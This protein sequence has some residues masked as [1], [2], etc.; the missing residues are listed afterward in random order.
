ME[1]EMRE[2]FGELS[3]AVNKKPK[4]F[5]NWEKAGIVAEFLS[6]VIIAGL[7]CWVT[8]KIG[9]ITLDNSKDI[10]NAQ[11]AV[12]RDQNEIA[13]QAQFAEYLPEASASR[14]NRRRATPL[15]SSLA[16]IRNRLS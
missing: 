14:L 8:Y 13:K 5:N 1:K 15:H 6:G 2:A 9:K 10:A 4:S 7:G 11:T 12:S 3:A 16:A